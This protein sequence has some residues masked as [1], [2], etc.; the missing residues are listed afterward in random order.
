MAP[1]LPLN[2]DIWLCIVEDY[3]L[4]SPVEIFNLAS[5]CRLLWAELQHKIYVADVLH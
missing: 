2:L 5:T 3:F 4:S 1:E